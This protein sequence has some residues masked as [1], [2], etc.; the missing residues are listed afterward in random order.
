MK[1]WQKITLIG[2]G[3]CLTTVVLGILVIAGGL[4]FLRHT[5]AEG[6]EVHTA[7]GKLPEF[8]R[9][10]VSSP[11][12]FLNDLMLSPLWKVEKQRD[13]SFVVK[14]R[15]IIPDSPFDEEGREF[16]FDFLATPDKPLPKDFRIRD[17]YLDGQ[18]TFSSFQVH[19]VFAKP[20]L[21]RMP[22][23]QSGQSVAIPVRELFER[24]IGPNS[25]SDLAIR[26]SSQHEIYVILHEQGADPKRSTT[27]ARVLPALRELADIAQSPTSYRVEERYAAFFRRFFDLPLKDQEIKRFPGM[28]DRDT[29]YGYFRVKPETS[30]GG[31]NIKISHPVY[32]PD[33]GTRRHSRLEKAEYSGKPY[34][35]N[36]VVFFLIEDNAVYLPGEYDERFGTFTGKESFDGTLEVLNDQDHVLLK[37]TDKFK[38]WQR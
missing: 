3:G 21:K 23:G 30:Y 16:L 34:Q 14:A 19:V 12:R 7:S 9:I 25:S 8:P 13:G 38:G 35:K 31:I 2:C 18:K 11:T 15:S 26:L 29:F 6:K 4:F 33:E 24:K 20:D 22:L 32:C 5:V 36:D 1:R 37:T 28:Q 10:D 27:F 17:E